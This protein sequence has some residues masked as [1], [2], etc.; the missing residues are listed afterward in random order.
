MTQELVVDVED[1]LESSHSDIVKNGDM[2]VLDVFGGQSSQ[3][4]KK[5]IENSEHRSGYNCWRDT[6]AAS[7]FYHPLSTCKIQK[8]SIADL[9]KWILAELDDILRESLT[10]NFK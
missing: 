10:D 3:L 9:G 7:C 8:P 2:L 5:E 6:N 4:V 1:C